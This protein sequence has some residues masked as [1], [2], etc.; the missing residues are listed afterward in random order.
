MRRAAGT[1]APIPTRSRV[2]P[3][4]PCT[5]PR[6]E[7]RIVGAATTPGWPIRRCAAQNYALPWTTPTAPCRSRIRTR[8][9]ASGDLRRWSG[10]VETDR[11]FLVGGDTGTPGNGTAIEAD[12]AAGVGP[13]VAQLDFTRSYESVDWSQSRFSDYAFIALDVVP[14]T[15]EGRATMTLRAINEQGVEFDRVVFSRDTRKAAGDE[16]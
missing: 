4:W 5:R 10:A 12:P 16:L 8:F 9:R 13:S 6:P 2:Q 14:A 15:P 7:A 11:D 3:T 1:E